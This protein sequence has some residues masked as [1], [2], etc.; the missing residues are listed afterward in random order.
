MTPMKTELIGEKT[1]EIATK[2]EDHSEHPFSIPNG[3]ISAL[4]NG[5]FAKRSPF[6]TEHVCTLSSLLRLF[7]LT[8]FLAQPMSYLSA[9]GVIVIGIAAWTAVNRVKD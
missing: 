4:V 2:E 5:D 3:H 6:M 7:M 9:A 8:T 1:E